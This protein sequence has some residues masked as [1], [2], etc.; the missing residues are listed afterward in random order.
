MVCVQEKFVL[1]MAVK[2][3][4]W[5]EEAKSELRFYTVVFVL[6]V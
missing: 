5:K 6:P 4:K 3:L 2:A 1:N